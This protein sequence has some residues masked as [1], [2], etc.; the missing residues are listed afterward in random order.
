M[1]SVLVS[2]AVYGFD[3]FDPERGKEKTPPPET[4]PPTTNPFQNQKPPDPPPPP[5]KGPQRDFTLIGTSLIG[6]YR[7]AILQAPDGKTFVQR[8]DASGK[9]PIDGYPGFFLLSVDARQ[10]KIAYPNDAPCQVSKTD[11]G[12]N[13]YSGGHQARLDLIR[14]G[15]IA[16]PPPPPAPVQEVAATVPPEVQNN[17][18]ASLIQQQA[19]QRELTPEEQRKREEELERRRE[20]YKNFQRQV[21]KDEDVPPGMRVVRTPFGDR[22]VPD[23]R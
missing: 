7:S 21:I 20:I 11:K 10:I 3:L 1:T 22:L 12:V 17:P 6:Q 8:L 4:P 9:T 13:C 15:A 14:K 5:P 18:F 16:P 2:N 19:Q 23:N